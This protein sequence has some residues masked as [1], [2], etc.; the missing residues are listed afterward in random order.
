MRNVFFQII[1][2]HKM[3]FPK[4]PVNKCMF[5]YDAMTDQV[6][7]FVS[8]V[9]IKIFQKKLET[10]WEIENYKSEELKVFENIKPYQK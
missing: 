6:D 2:R 10:V 5:S 7:K 9:K 8:K 4:I 3:H 1:V